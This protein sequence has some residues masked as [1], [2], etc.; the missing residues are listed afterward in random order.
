MMTK[1]QPILDELHAVREQLLA[2]AGGT[3][4]GLVARIRENQKSSGRTIRE[5]RRTM[6]CTEA[7]VVRFLAIAMSLARAR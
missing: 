4:A 2:D 7:R 5:T 3:L 1:T 6:N